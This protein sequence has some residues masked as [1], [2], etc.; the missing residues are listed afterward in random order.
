MRITSTTGTVDGGWDDPLPPYDPERMMILAF[1]APEIRDD[2]TLLEKVAAEYSGAAMIGCSTAGEIHGT[3]LLDGTVSL[4]LMEFEHTG[5]RS[6]C[7]AVPEP[8]ESFGAGRTLASRLADP[9]LQ[10]MIVLSDGTL[11]NGSELARGM[12]SVTGTGITV[13]GGLAADGDRFEHTWVFGEGRCR[14]GT[15]VAVGLYGDKVRVGHGSQGGWDA[16]GP[17]RVVTGADGAVLHSID[18]EP[19]LDLYRRY[20]GEEAE[21]LPATALHFPLA[22]RPPEG[23]GASVVRTVLNVDHDERTMTFAGD[24]PEGWRV[25]LM[26]ANFDRI[27]DGAS[28]AASS[29]SLDPV[30]GGP[31]LYIAITCVGRRLV[32]G[33]R[34]E[35][36]LEAVAEHLRADDDLVGFY[37]YGELSP[38][39]DGGCELHN[40]TMTLTSI[41]ER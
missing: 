17:E 34:A 4:A 1:A 14:S 26:Q 19:A 22:L 27:I 24:V 2:P 36:E 20:L 25:Q 35:E 23:D 6:A 9:D 8:A 39:R 28:S 7:A 41:S 40:Q 32:L 15:V 11:A 10:A 33:Q 30:E 3:A 21:G 38:I 12:R 16:F 37:S 29:P 18:D 5:V 31:A 13:T